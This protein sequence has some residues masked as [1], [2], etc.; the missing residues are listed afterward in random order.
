MPVEIVDTIVIVWLVTKDVALGG[1]GGFIVYLY[2]YDKAIRSGKPFVFRW[3]SLGVN[4]ALGMFVSYVV[5]NIIPV[6][7]FGREALLLMCG[8][9]AYSILV[10]AEGRFAT[11]LFDKIDRMFGK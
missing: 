10:I 6:D 8:F 5:A 9:T 1:I 4:I 11:A 7:L 3:S 2:D